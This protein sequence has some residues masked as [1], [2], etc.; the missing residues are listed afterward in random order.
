[1]P[2]ELDALLATLA[3]TRGLSFRRAEAIK[4]LARLPDPAAL[5]AILGSAHDPAAEVRR[6]TARVLGLL[7]GLPGAAAAA[8]V[9]A[10]DPDGRV[11]ETLARALAGSPAPWAREVL[12]TLAHDQAFFVSKAAERALEAQRPVAP[13]PTATAT[14]MGLPAAPMATATP[15]RPPAST[16]TRPP[17]STP[18]RPPASTPTIQKPAPRPARSRPA[19]R[20]LPPKK[21]LPRGCGTLFLLGGL[22]VAGVGWWSRVQRRPQPVP[23]PPERSAQELSTTL[24]GKA[25]DSLRRLTQ[26]LESPQA[27]VRLRAARALVDLG[28]RRA[29]PV[30]ARAARRAPDALEESALR[31]A[32]R[33]LL[34]RRWTGMMPGASR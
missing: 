10:A 12:C 34:E 22:A 25:T 9:L 27:Q 14:N 2:E 21:A 11:R 19:A 31:E 7:G 17:A 4:R 24:D 20:P 32:T 13:T 15:T 16:P 6:E 1:M 28:D 8:G 29:A 33:R 26:L 3:D 23:Q 18:T 5:Q 30:L